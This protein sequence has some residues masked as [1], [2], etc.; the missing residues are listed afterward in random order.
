DIEFFARYGFNRAH[1]TD[2]AV[3]TGQTAYLKAHY[4]LEF[5]TALMTTERNNIEKLGFLIADARRTGLT[6]L[7]PS[8]TH[9]EVEFI[10]EHLPDGERAIR[11]GLSAI[12]NVGEEAM[13][14]IVE[15]RK[16]GGPF[17]SLDDLANRVDLRKVNR[18]ALECLIQAG[19]L[20][21]FG[22]R[23][24]LLAVLDTLLNSSGHT[25]EARDVG[26][27]SLFGDSF[28]LA[29]AI[30]IPSHYPPIST[31]QI[32]EW[33]KEL[34]GVYLSEHPLAQQE[35]ELL[36]Q[37][38]TNTTLDRMG[39]EMPGQQLT[40]LGMIQRIRRITTK[41]GDMMAFVT[42][43]SPGGVAEVV[44]FPRTYERCR[45]LLTEGRVLV[46][47]GKLDARQD[48]EDH[49][50]MADWF[51]VPQDLLR[52]TEFGQM[53][54]ETPYLAREA[55]RSY[56]TARPV[57][58]PKKSSA[59]PPQRQTTITEAAPALQAPPALQ[60]APALQAPPA[61]D[62]MRQTP[63]TNVSAIPEPPEEPPALP[64]TLCVTLHRSV[65]S[66]TD[67][68]LLHRLYQVIQAQ[69]GEDHFVIYLQNDAGISPKLVELSFPNEHTCITH[70]LRRQIEELIG[71]GNVRVVMAGN[72]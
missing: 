48:R 47:S 25:H 11:I 15:A 57:A 67:Y 26:Q 70:A 17:K 40:A 62:I 66:E 23:P 65:N 14:L 52:P 13:R 10:I 71:A 53:E 7:G 12:K 58:T 61:N 60:A 41:K 9:S 32:L 30:Q 37:S 3:I 69:E 54:R 56:T 31:R 33:E 63:A 36:E 51:K 27:F 19:A 29:N 46:V 72:L 28:G 6:V 4:P 20:D 45:E 64:A 68:H 59:T 24:G 34:L 42:L 21:E 22:P 1:A 18:R 44:V 50:L 5:M 55:P 43:E 8:L 2:Y 49:P 35:R 38:L 39:T 16:A